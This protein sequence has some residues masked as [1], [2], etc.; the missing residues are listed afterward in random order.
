[1]ANILAYQTPAMGHFFPISVLLTELRN[2]GHHIGLRTLAAGVEFGRTM[3]FATDPV[4]PRI[5]AMPLD[6]AGALTIQPDV[7]TQVIIDPFVG[8]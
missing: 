4:D 1:M 3:G 8:K 7:S 2:R 5:E 6:D